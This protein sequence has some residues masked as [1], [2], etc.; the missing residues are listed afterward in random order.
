MG[1]FT[2]LALSDLSGLPKPTPPILLAV[3]SLVSLV[4]FFNSMTYKVV[5]ALSPPCV[6]L[7]TNMKINIVSKIIPGMSKNSQE[8]YGRIM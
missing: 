4:S 8:R 1:M 6:H 3:L 2:L 5:E 7:L